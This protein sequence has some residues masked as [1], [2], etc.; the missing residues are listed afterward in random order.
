MSISCSTE[1]SFLP[2]LFFVSRLRASHRRAA[3]KRQCAA[4]PRCRS[5][6]S[7]RRISTS[8]WS[9]VVRRS[10]ASPHWTPF[11]SC[12]PRN[13]R[14]SSRTFSR[15]EGRGD[16]GWLH[17]VRR[18]QRPRRV[19]RCGDGEARRVRS[20]LFARV[21]G[22]CGEVR[23][24]GEMYGRHEEPAVRSRWNALRLLACVAGTRLA[25]CTAAFAERHI[26]APSSVRHHRAA[27]ECVPAL[28]S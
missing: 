16:L 21:E 27:L 26:V 4:S 14:T 28:R 3:T 19:R 11:A 5:P 20:H 23:D 15:S 25:R 2:S 22:R 17:G 13:E 24:G 12:T 6:S 7:R 8:T 18:R 10:S 9:P 1:R